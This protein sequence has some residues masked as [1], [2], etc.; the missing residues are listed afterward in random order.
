MR[1]EVILILETLLLFAAATIGMTH[2]IVDST[3]SAPM[4]DWI[5]SKERLSLIS[6]LVECYQCCGFWVG[7]FMGAIVFTTFNPLV[8]FACGCASSF[9]SV[10]GAGHI[11]YLEAV[12]MI[13]L[14]DIDDDEAEDEAKDEAEDEAD[15]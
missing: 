2:I 8:L 5:A 12:S 1:L 14:G 10:W 9:L 15:E 13:D 11:A 6:K 7:I 3:L 4:R